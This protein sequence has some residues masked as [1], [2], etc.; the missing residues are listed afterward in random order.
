MGALSPVTS[1]ELHIRKT[2]AKENAAMVHLS[3]S[4]Y[5]EHL[6]SQR[7]SKPLRR[8]ERSQRSDGGGNRS[9]LRRNRRMALTKG[10]IKYRSNRVV[11]ASILALVCLKRGSISA[12]L[13]SSYDKLEPPT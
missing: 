5:A 11:V 8:R 3:F 2:T 4:T 12:S 1:L 13:V 7:C 9:N 10:K 6:T